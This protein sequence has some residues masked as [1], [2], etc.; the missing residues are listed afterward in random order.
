MIYITVWKCFDFD[1]ISKIIKNNLIFSMCLCVLT[2]WWHAVALRVVSVRCVW[3]CRLEGGTV[4]SLSIRSHDTS[5]SPVNW[6]CR[7]KKNKETNSSSLYSSQKNI[8]FCHSL[9]CVWGRTQSAVRNTQTLLFV[10]K[11]KGIKATK[12]SLVDCMNW[13]NQMV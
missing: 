6:S 7:G 8:C 4:L 9:S 5:L 2:V 11:T 13:W 3:S 1:M 12:R 10:L